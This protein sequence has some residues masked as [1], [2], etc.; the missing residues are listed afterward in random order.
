M[1]QN[2]AYSGL[3]LRDFGTL[4]VYFAPFSKVKKFW[5]AVVERGYAR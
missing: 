4:L 3:I 5:R 1:W 2:L